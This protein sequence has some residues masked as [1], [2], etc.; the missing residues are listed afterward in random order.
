M[1]FVFDPDH[2][3]E[4]SRDALAAMI[5]AA[6]RLGLA[7]GVAAVQFVFNADMP[8]PSALFW[9]PIGD[10]KTIERA[11]DAAH[12]PGDNGTNYLAGVVSKVAEMVATHRAS[13]SAGRPL[14][15]AELGWPGGRIVQFTGD[16]PAESGWAF[17]AYSGGT[18][19]E[20]MQV[21]AAGQNLLFPM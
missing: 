1:S 9:R 6:K 7:K 15:N 13:G 17:F 11:S 18:P 5:D 14:K 2:T 12:G 21:S 4:W 8:Y 10:M 16:T 19:E 3:D 20:D